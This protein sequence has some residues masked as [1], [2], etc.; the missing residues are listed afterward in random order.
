[1]ALTLSVIGGAAGIGSF[2]TQ[3][4]AGLQSTVT[5]ILA[6]ALNTPDYV[7]RRKFA[8]KC[9]AN[10][11][12]MAQAIAVK[13]AN[14]IQSANPTKY[15]DLTAVQDADITGALSAIFTQTAYSVILPS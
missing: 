6:E 15:A 8:Q 5:A 13:V 4:Q 11:Q 12:P 14:Q 7:V 3:V 1:V 10:L 2:V 9:E